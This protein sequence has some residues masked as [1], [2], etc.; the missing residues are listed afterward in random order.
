MGVG[1]GEGAEGDREQR[2][3]CVERGDRAKET[4]EMSKNGDK[5]RGMDGQRKAEI[6][7][8]IER[9][10]EEEREKEGRRERQ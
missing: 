5:K 6:A 2:V 4:R 10:R 1:F 8:L 7:Y 9:R 3:A